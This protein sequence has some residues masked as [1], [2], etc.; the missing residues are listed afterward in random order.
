M[1]VLVIGGG[2]REHALGWKIS[3]S[4]LLKKLWFA[5]GNP[6][7]ATLG[8]NVSLSLEAIPSFAQEHKIDLVVAGPEQPLV[9][10]LADKLAA[11]DIPCFGPVSGAAQLE[12]SKAFSK[13]VMDATGVPTAKYEVFTDFNKA[14]DS[15]RNWSHPLVVK[16]DGLAAGK[17]VTICQSFH[18]TEQALTEAMKDQKFGPAGSKVVLEEFLVGTEVSFHII[19]DGIRYLPLVTAKDHKAL[20]E[21]DKG[22]NTGGMGTYA[23]NPLIDDA[24]AAR[25][26]KEACEPILDYMRDQ[27][28]AFRGVL[29]AG[30]ML[31][32]NGP[33]VLEYNVRFGDP[34][35]QVMLPLL[36][37]DLL[38]V[39]YG[40][41]M[42]QLPE[43]DFGW[44]GSAT[45]V[46]LAAEGYP[47]SAR[48]GDPIEK[49]PQGN[50]QGQ[51]FHAGTKLNDK[52]L[53]VTSGGRVMGVTAWGDS[54]ENA[55]NQAYQM[56]EEI[57]FNGKYYRRDIGV[58]Q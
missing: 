40:A 30:L 4:P 14:L 6:G 22:P 1:Q 52:G 29:F 38:P 45:C 13:Q 54:P 3:Q 15:A 31:T 46:V 2:G 41:A 12:G 16:A 44:K 26:Q 19:S 42:G 20:L 11:V 18:E 34:E 8:E 39:L 50:S 51:V 10:G 21:G 58:A 5:P 36:D 28:H 9:D 27:G 43:G 49:V 37:F 23:P 33:K 53:L 57:Q 17:G 47:A 55:R 35:T 7:T 32:E 48:K 25:I 56:V 24:L